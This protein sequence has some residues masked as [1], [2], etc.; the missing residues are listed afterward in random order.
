LHASRFIS[1]IHDESFVTY[2]LENLLLY[3]VKMLT[4]SS[5]ATTCDRPT[6]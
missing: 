1:G 6:F 2:S 5:F 4:T 3:F